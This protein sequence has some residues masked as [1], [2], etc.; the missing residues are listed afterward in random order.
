MITRHFVNGLFIILILKTNG[1]LTPQNNNF[2]FVKTAT[3][4][5]KKRTWLPRYMG[6]QKQGRVQMW[7]CNGHREEGGMK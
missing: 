7:G 3:S 1:K 4:F 5:H 6:W 2:G